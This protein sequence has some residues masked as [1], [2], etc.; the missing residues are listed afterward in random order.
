MDVVIDGDFGVA[1]AAVE[2]VG[3]VV[4]GILEAI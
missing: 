2:I 4:G 1:G 3:E